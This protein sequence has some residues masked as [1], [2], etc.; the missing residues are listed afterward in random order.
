MSATHCVYL[1]L[2]PAQR[3]RRRWPAAYV[4]TLASSESAGHI[5]CPLAILIDI[6]VDRY[7]HSSGDKIANVNFLRQYRTHALKFQ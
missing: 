5:R 2:S 4:T 3:M 7:K 6:S 1:S